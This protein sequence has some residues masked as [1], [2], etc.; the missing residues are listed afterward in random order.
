MNEYFQLGTDTGIAHLQLNRPERLNTMAPAFFPA[1]RDAVRTLHDAAH[2]RVLVISSTGKH[3]CAGMALDVFGGDDALLVT[4]T[5]RARLNFQDT[6]RKLIDCF[7]ALDEARFPVI[8]AIQAGTKRL[9]SCAEKAWNESPTLRSFTGA[10][11]RRLRVVASAARSIWP[12]P[13]TFACARPKRFSPC[14]RSTS[15]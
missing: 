12:R 15:A 10:S 1:L 11:L 7:T 8:C 9:R 5:A 4:G 13:A 2:V 3:F 6:L 14:K